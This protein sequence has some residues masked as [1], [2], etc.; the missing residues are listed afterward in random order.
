MW[1]ESHRGRRQAGLGCVWW[2][3]FLSPSWCL[4]QILCAASS[5]C[6]SSEKGMSGLRPAPN[7]PEVTRVRTQL[8]GLGLV[9]QFS[10]CTG[11]ACARPTVPC[12]DPRRSLRFPLPSLKSWGGPP[13]SFL[14]W[15]KGG[16]R[17][18]GGGP[19]CFLPLTQLLHIWKPIPCPIQ[20]CLPR[21]S[22]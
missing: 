13:P 20:S 8:C 6:L 16:I 18:V 2:V 22:N 7:I 9:P 11:R 4:T 3:K 10:I 21:F 17:R 1:P 14:P 12:Q 5:S 19:H 15:R